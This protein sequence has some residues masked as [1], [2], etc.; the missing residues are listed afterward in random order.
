[1]LAGCV[2]PPP[3]AVERVEATHPLELELPAALE[4]WRPELTR[5]LNA[6]HQ[7]FLARS[8][9]PAAP[10]DRPLRL[11]VTASVPE[12]AELLRSIDFEGRPEVAR[13]ISS[14]R[15]AVVPLPRADAL[16]VAHGPPRTWLET[17]R[18]EAAH[19]LAVDRPA[20]RAAPVWFQEGWAEALGVLPPDRWSTQAV[21]FPLLR[22]RSPNQYLERVLD[23]LPAEG[24]LD[25]R[26]HW[27]EAALALDPGPRPWQR[28][29]SWTVRD[30]LARATP[31]ADYRSRNQRGR[32]FDPAG[33]DGRFLLAAYPGET[34]DFQLLPVWDGAAP[35]ELELG[36]GDSGRPE[37]GLL[38]EGGGTMRLRVRVSRNGGA[39]AYLEPKGDVA[40]QPLRGEAFGQSASG[41]HRLRL[42][43][44]GA[45][46]L[47][48]GPGTRERV[49]LDP[50]VLAPPFEVRVYVRDG[51]LR[52]RHAE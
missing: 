13:T 45:Q 5:Q 48:T 2:S 14:K 3:A 37:G 42:E 41:S 46:L 25:A 33:G 24:L 12:A 49:Q 8:R 15:V 21:S 9:W 20:L 28:V 51:L 43:R 27:V 4:A 38:I 23:Q 1:L 31:L 16:L 50:D 34:A 7:S 19:L 6:L 22:L 40:R 39:T 26:R 32:E 17:L 10:E 44:D 11:R 18:H 35:L 52:V 47:F 29:Q 30:Y 36:Y